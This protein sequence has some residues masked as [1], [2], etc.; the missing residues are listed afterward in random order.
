[1]NREVELEPL[2]NSGRG[3]VTCDQ[4]MSYID[5]LR[6]GRAEAFDDAFA[7]PEAAM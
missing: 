5:A 2:K 6:F 3:A 1:M 4:S 7:A